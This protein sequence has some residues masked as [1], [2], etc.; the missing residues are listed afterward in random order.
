MASPASVQS[1]G[2][3]LRVGTEGLNMVSVVR[4]PHLSLISLL[5][6]SS[7]SG[8]ASRTA[9]EVRAAVHSSARFALSA[10]P[11]RSP[12]VCPDCAHCPVPPVSD[13]SAAQQAEVLREIPETV[14]LADLARDFGDELPP[15]WRPAAERPRRW[16]NSFAAAS[17]AGWT[18]IEPLWRR[19]QPLI[20]RESRRVGAAA[21]RGGL[22]A[23]LNSLHPRIH[24]RD[25]ELIVQASPDSVCDLAGRK[26]ALVPMICSPNG[27]AV[28]FNR[29]GVAFVGYPVRGFGD[30]GRYR[31]DSVDPSHDALA[32]VLGPARARVLRAVNRVLTIGQLA[33]ELQCEP[34][35]ASYHCG[36]LESAGLIARERHGQAV[37]V[38][39]TGRGDALADLLSS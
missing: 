9:Q 1:R 31:C 22:S 23:L 39:R 19:Y 32:L 2:Y 34:C 13:V 3:R 21:V 37:W 33:V 29:P 20:D 8:P 25:G 15:W 4:V 18:V 36:R 24:Y 7:P 12:H 14:L 35:T 28:S 6:S 11:Q 10:V 30:Q 5:L 17:L 27:T 16:L 38:T 26:L